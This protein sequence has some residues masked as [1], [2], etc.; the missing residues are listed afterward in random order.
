MKRPREVCC[1]FIPRQRHR[2]IGSSTR[3]FA[4][5][6]ATSVGP[7]INGN[8]IRGQLGFFRPDKA[9]P[10][11]QAVAEVL[12][13]EPDF[14]N[15]LLRLITINSDD[16]TLN[17]LEI[18]TKFNQVFQR[19]GDLEAYQPL[20]EKYYIAAFEALLAD[21]VTYVE[22]RAGFSSLY[23]LDGNSWGYRERAQL[24]WTI[25]NRVREANPDFDLKLVYSA[26]P[27]DTGPENLAIARTGGRVAQGLAE[28]ELRRWLRSRW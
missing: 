12:R 20:F 19:T 2:Q 13:R 4:S 7:R 25:R 21:H 11:Y 22:L 26:T 10:G 3:A 27:L 28:T 15:K 23:D 9:P 5:R 17:G 8:A 14:P 24:M 1:I 6:I 16:D 18:W